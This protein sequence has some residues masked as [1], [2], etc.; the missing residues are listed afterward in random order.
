L[1]IREQAFGYQ[2]IILQDRLIRSG[3]RPRPAAIRSSLI[4]AWWL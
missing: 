4:H 1:T 3:R 2:L